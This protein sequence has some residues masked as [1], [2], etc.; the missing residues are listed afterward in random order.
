LKPDFA[1]RRKVGNL[2]EGCKTATLAAALL[3]LTKVIKK[4][5]FKVNGRLQIRL[6]DL[7]LTII[8]FAFDF[9]NFLKK[10]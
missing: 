2:P 9:Y 8:A 6:K 10:N 1:V 3:P 7:K 4:A 5:K